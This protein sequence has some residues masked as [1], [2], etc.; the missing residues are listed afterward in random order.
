MSKAIP[1]RKQE[2]KEEIKTYRSARRVLI[3]I[4]LR[5][6]VK[7]TKKKKKEK[8]KTF[9][10]FKDQRLN[11]KSRSVTPTKIEVRRLKTGLEM[12]IV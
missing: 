9:V 1:N 5:K 3:G 2:D 8:K 11:P 12:G 10:F 4:I 6:G 7:V